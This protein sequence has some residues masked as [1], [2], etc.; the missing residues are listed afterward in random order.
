MFGLEPQLLS[1]TEGA[2]AEVCVELL[3]GNITDPVTVN[4]R[5]LEGLSKCLDLTN[6]V[7]RVQMWIS[8]IYF[9]QC[10]LT[11]SMDSVV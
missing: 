4:V 8:M 2:A 9:V 5:T 3:A 11:L 7:I 1:V 10:K 6:F